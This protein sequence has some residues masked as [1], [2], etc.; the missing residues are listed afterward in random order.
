L[1]AAHYGRATSLFGARGASNGKN[2]GAPLCVPAFG[3]IYSH[4]DILN[5]YLWWALM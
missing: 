5:A 4:I 3:V 2:K 1:Q